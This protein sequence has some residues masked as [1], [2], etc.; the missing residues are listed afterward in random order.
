MVAAPSIAAERP[1][2]LAQSLAAKTSLAGG[3]ARSSMPD[4][5]LGT[6]GLIHRRLRARREASTSDAT[7]RCPVDQSLAPALGDV[8]R[9]GVGLVGRVAGHVW[10]QVGHL[11]VAGIDVVQDDGT[12]L[13]FAVVIA[14]RL[15]LFGDVG[16]PPL[17][18]AEGYRMLLAMASRVRVP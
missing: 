3:P 8:D 9:T 6:V 5:R 16:D 7:C 14:Q 18:V 10:C 17:S 12:V 13:G 11:Q 2:H 1:G 4:R 15:Q